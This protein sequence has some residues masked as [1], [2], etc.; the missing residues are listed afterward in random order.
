[1][2]QILQI[3]G[4][5][6]KR[7][8][9]RVRIAPPW[10]A[11]VKAATNPPGFSLKPRKEGLRGLA[12]A[13]ERSWR[14]WEESQIPSALPD[15]PALLRENTPGP[16]AQERSL[17]TPG[18]RDRLAGPGSGSRQ[19][20]RGESPAA[21]STRAQG[22]PRSQPSARRRGA[23]GFP[24]CRVRGARRMRTSSSAERAT[25][26]SRWVWSGAGARGSERRARGEGGARRGVGGARPPAPRPR[27]GLGGAVPGRA[28]S[29]RP[30]RQIGRAH[31]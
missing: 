11:R 14:C 25:E 30:A 4:R 17:L 26:G 27:P 3:A 16:I 21:G 8:Q 15:S 10:E 1:M 13:P 2:A 5:A 24:R 7:K 29:S 18:P 19:G 20:G 12:T 9:A 23:P 28:H 22:I 31:V 6:G